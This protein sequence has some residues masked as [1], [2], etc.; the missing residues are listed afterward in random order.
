MQGFLG[1]LDILVQAIRILRFDQL[2]EFDRF[3][4]ALWTS[5]VPELIDLGLAF[6][7]QF[8]ILL[9]GFLILGDQV[10]LVDLVHVLHHR[11]VP[12]LLVERLWLQRL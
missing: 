8:I 12:R 2:Q 5:D 6:L 4:L 7:A 10:R 3:T 9:R 11:L 1:K